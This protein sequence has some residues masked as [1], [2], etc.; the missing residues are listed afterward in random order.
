MQKAEFDRLVDIWLVEIFIII[1][2]QAGEF[3]ALDEFFHQGSVIA[4]HH[5]S[6]LSLQLL[7]VYYF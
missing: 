4:F 3:P 6:D 1:H 2:E 7:L 5:P